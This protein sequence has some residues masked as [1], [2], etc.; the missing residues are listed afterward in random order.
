[1]LLTRIGMDSKMIL[2]GDVEQSDLQVQQ[3]GCF[4]SIIDKLQNTNNIGFSVLETSDIVRNSIIAD[5]IYKI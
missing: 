4:I 2:T 3:Q 5:I 1:M